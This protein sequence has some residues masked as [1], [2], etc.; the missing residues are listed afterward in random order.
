MKQIIISLAF[1]FSICS[2]GQETASPV[3]QGNIYSHGAQLQEVMDRFTVKDLPGISVAVYSAE[4][5][6]WTGSSGYSRT[7]TKSKMTENNLQYIQSVSKTF[8]AVAILKLHE[9]GRIRLEEPMTK[10]LPGKYRSWIKN[11][12]RITV[13]MLLS[14]TSGIA[15]YVTDPEYIRTVLLTPLKVAVMSDV[16]QCLENEAPQFEPGERYLY[17]N[18]NFTLLALMAD[19]ITGD[20]ASYI[21]ANIFKPLGLKNTYYR[22]DKIYLNNP[23]LVDSYWDLLNSG[24]PANVTPMQKA[25]VAALIGDDGIICTPSDAVKFLAG[26]MEGRLLKDSS[27]AL[28]K[29]WVRNSEGREVYGLGLIRFEFNGLVGYGHG[30]GGIGSGC[31][32]IYVP[33]K[34]TYVF[35]ATNIGCV[36]DGTPAIKASEMRDELCKII[37][38]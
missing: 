23:R 5:G 35:L 10:Y 2:Y 30:G 16:L 19:F 22:N 8:M 34:N 37:F 4:E 28:M 18:T 17:T 9:Q 21:T 15:E 31:A 26:L 36:W 33:S 20:H 38:Q 1:F 14:H 13:K 6:W 24:R 32:L 12:D 11:A 7:E 3:K 29:Q 27:L 25:N